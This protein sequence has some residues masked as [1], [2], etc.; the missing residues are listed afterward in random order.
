MAPFILLGLYTGSRS[1]VIRNLRWDWIDFKAC[2]MRRRALG[3]SERKNK[4][5]PIVKLGSRILSHLRRWRRLDI[6]RPSMSASMTAY[7]S[8]ECFIP[9]LRFWKSLG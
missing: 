9:G 1:S 6:R 2:T 7:R 3:A 5:T 4:R 8:T